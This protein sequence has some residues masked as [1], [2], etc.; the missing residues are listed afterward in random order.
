MVR[1]GGRGVEGVAVTGVVTFDVKGMS[2]AVVELDPLR[3]G[4]CLYRNVEWFK[5][6]HHHHLLSPSSSSSYS[7]PYHI[8][9]Y[10]HH[11]IKPSPF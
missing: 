6:G 7:I 8:R 2:G 11:K 3:D 10:I 1:K 4:C 9:I 5:G